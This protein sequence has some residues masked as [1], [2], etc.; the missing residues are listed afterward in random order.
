MAG[1]HRLDTK[2]EPYLE[3]QAEAPSDDP[4]DRPAAPQVPGFQVLAAA[5][6]SLEHKLLTLADH[7]DPS[8]QEV[9]PKRWPVLHQVPAGE[10]RSSLLARLLLADASGRLSAQRLQTPEGRLALAG[11]EAVV[12][13]LCALALACRPGAVRCCIDRTAK[14]ALAAVL[15]EL[16]GVLQASSPHGRAV[17]HDVAAWSPLHWACLGY[18][19]WLKLVGPEEPLLRR[20]VHMSLPRHLLGMA[21]RRRWARRERAPRAA[22]QALHEAG[23]AWPC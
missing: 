10:A 4:P 1:V 3:P 6:R 2:Q 19:D 7:A 17:R 22:L 20:V 11:R 9:H 14:Q 8:W 15:G 16:F 12:R 18:L 5:C 23:G 21:T 13:N